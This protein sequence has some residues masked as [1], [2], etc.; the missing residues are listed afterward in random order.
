MNVIVIRVSERE[1]GTLIRNIYPA[2][3]N[4]CSVPPPVTS[5]TPRRGSPSEEWV[6]K[7]IYWSYYNNNLPFPISNLRRQVVVM[8]VLIPLAE[9]TRLRMI[10]LGLLSQL[11]DAIEIDTS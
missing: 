2:V 4:R 7:K 5:P 9:V 8:E 3:I 10:D 6:K 1:F 11:E